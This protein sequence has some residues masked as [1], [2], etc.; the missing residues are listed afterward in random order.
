MALKAMKKKEMLA[1]SLQGKKE[2]PFQKLLGK[3]DSVL[4]HKIA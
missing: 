2:Q 4:N 3:D 1:Y